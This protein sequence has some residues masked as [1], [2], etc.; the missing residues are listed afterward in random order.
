M[1]IYWQSFL[2][3][4][5]RICFVLEKTHR[6]RGEKEVEIKHTTFT[7]QF[8]TTDEQ[9]VRVCTK[10]KSRWKAKNSCDVV[11]EIRAVGVSV[12][13]T[14]AETFEFAHDIAFLFPHAR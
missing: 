3:F 11:V 6:W 1:Y 10:I 9:D 7:N 4:V 12:F 5:T 14:F 8:Q 13:A 2:S